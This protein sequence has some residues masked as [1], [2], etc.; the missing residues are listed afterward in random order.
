[1]NDKQIFQRAID[2]YGIV[3][4]LHMVVEELSEL[5]SAICKYLRVDHVN[6]VSDIIPNILE[7]TADVEIMTAQIRLL[8]GDTEIDEIK[9]MKIDRLFRRMQ[10]EGQT[11]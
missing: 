7:E 4:Q 2:H 8:F 11:D 6:K 9:R 1:M 10:K 5:T 3:N